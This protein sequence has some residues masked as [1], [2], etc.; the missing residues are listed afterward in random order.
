M[1]TNGDTTIYEQ[2]ETCIASFRLLSERGVPLVS[3]SGSID[4]NNVCAFGAVV[5]AAEESGA[6]EI[7]VVLPSGDY[8]CARAFGV[9]CAAYDRLEAAGRRLLIVCPPRAFPR[10]VI[11]LLRL[12]FELFDSVAD[13][14]S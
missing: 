9:L 5:Q 11:S 14:I 3:V 1:A 8:V 10:R 12:P 2:Y 7:M 4:I 6:P 13:A